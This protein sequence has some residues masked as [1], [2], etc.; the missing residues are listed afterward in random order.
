MK[1][2]KYNRS[3]VSNLFAPSKK[4]AKPQIAHQVNEGLG[5]SANTE[6]L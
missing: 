3:I 5:E 6:F 1:L 2:E 4:G